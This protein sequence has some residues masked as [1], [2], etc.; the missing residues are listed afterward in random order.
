MEVFGKGHVLPGIFFLFKEAKRRVVRHHQM[1]LTM[2]LTVFLLTVALIQ[3][4]AGAFSQNVTISGKDL[5]LK[6]VFKTIK[7]QTGYT[8][9]YNNELLKEAKPVTIDVKDAPLEDVLRLCFEGQTLGYDV[10]NKTVFVTKRVGVLD[11]TPA[12]QSRDSLPK[13]PREVEGIVVNENGQP[14][15][16]A[17][18]MVKAT[19]KMALT[20]EKGEFKLLDVSSNSFLTV[21]YVGYS[22]KQISF[23]Q[24]SKVE[25]RLSQAVNQLDQ[26]QIVAYGTTTDRLNTGDITTVT[27]TTIEKQPV[28]NPLEAIQGR[29]PGLYINQSTGL[30]GSAFSVQVMGRNSVVNGNDPLYVV[31][32]VP[33]PSELVQGIGSI[34]GTPSGSMSA[35][36]QSYGN[37]LSFINPAD[38][39]SIS[40]LKDAAATA[41]WGSRGANGVVLITTKR[42]KPGK[43]QVTLNAYT[44]GAVVPHFLPLMNTQQYLEMRNEADVNDGVTPNLSNAPDLVDWD[45]TRYTNWQKML[46]GGTAQYTDVQGNVSGGNINTQYLFGGGYHKEGTVFPGNFS[47][48]RGSF[49]AS[50]NTASDDQRFK[51]SFSANY[52]YDNNYLVDLTSQIASLPPDAPPPFNPNGT[53]NWADVNGTYTWPSTQNPYA[54]LLTPYSGITTNLVANSLVSYEV[55]SGLSVKCNLGYTDLHVNETIVGPTTASDPTFDAPASTEFFTSAIR[56]WI[57][58]PQLAYERHIAQGKLEALVGSTFTQNNT[59]GQ[60]IFAYGFPS[61]ALLNDVQAASN[62]SIASVTNLVYKYNAAFGRVNYNWGDNYLV[63]LTARRDGSSRFG[64]ANQFHDFAAAG[65][66]WIFSNEPFF[67]KGKT[68][69]SYG[70]LRASYGTTG[71]D[72][73]GDYKFLSLYSSS[74]ALPYSGSSGI[75]STSLYNPNL[76]WEETK[77]MEGGVDLGFWKDRV[78]LKGAY[79]R[80]MTSNQ[81]VNYA[82]SSV[83]GFTSISS[84]LAAKVQNV[85]TELT[86]TSTNIKSRNF[87]WTTSLTLTIPRN[88]LVGFPNLATSSYSGTYV[89]GQPLTIFKAYKYAGV[90]PNTG[91]YEFQS[92]KGGDTANPSYA[93]DRTALINTDPKVY[94]G[95]D[96]LFAYHGFQLDIFFYFMERQGRNL[97]YNDYYGTEPGLEGFTQP[98][99]VLDRW[100]KP[101]DVKPFEMFS[102]STG[103]AYNAY[104]NVETSSQAFTNTSF[105]KLKNISLSYEVP[106]AWKNK[107]R[108]KDLVIYVRGQNLYTFTHHYY[109]YDP[110][111][112]SLSS[113]SM[114]RV[115]TGGIKV[116]L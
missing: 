100:Q 109:G 13:T 19:G 31:D 32:G 40:V 57:V 44:G 68:I 18:V 84:N 58:E 91:I 86:V 7:A 22:A 12:P 23:K 2:K 15:S 49:H 54:L 4:Q 28:D 64:P 90:D 37:P 27:S 50:V 102:E 8:F 1:L 35:Q 51:M 47:D 16:G 46:L 99:Q 34:L 113:V 59:T 25:V 3:V 79:Y 87:N 43:L 73:I 114:L 94:G 80:T 81:L 112:Q 88:K 66:G 83:T 33:Y 53:L 5:P 14:L 104:T 30:P 21:T 38:I 45:T 98:V 10:Q 41:I 82:L 78:L 11:P 103:A 56:S 39:E 29:V 52:L 101:G 48:Q 74:S 9:F 62:V 71:S 77:K 110:E 72:Q 96:N 55:L 92:G 61:N 6:A 116:T 76:A 108:I 85:G 70:K 65:A 89:I 95:F 75:S 115:V 26:V 42:G 36:A 60:E 67:Q 69:L 111:T 63:N 20:N 106:G 105:I 107:M 24:G 97:L 17:S 93:T